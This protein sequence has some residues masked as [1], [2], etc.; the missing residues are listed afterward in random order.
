MHIK[1]IT[2]SVISFIMIAASCTSYA[3]A[4]DSKNETETPAERHNITFVDFDGNVLK[5][6]SLLP[7][8]KIAYDWFDESSL[9]SHINAYTERIFSSWDQTPATSDK[10]I[11]IKALYKTASISLDSM[12]KKTEYYKRNGKISTKGLKVNITVNT[13]T[14]SKDK[15]GNYIIDTRII[16]VSASCQAEPSDLSAVFADSDTGTI[17]I[18]PAGQDKIICSYDITCCDYIGDVNDNGTVDSV[19]AS[20]V[21]SAYATASASKNYVLTDEFVKCADADRNNTVDARDASRILM[22]YAMT[23]VNNSL[24]WDN[25]DEFFA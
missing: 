22:Y 25:I 9:S 2:A 6:F 8:E 19:D 20:A 4:A 11:T 21:L 16:D 14:P 15:E 12:P 1:K 13:Q 23:S 5:T 10:D 7:D 24:D 17:K 3:M 18:R